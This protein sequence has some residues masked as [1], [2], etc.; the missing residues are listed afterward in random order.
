MMKKVICHECKK[1]CVETEEK[2]HDFVINGW[3]CPKC[4]EVIFDEDVIQ[5]ILEYN[6]Y[7]EKDSILS[8]GRR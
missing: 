7:Q 4:G 5:P 6:K 1:E 3:K 2:F 8:G